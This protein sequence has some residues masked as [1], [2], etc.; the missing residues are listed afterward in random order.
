M[1]L[2]GA[3]SPVSDFAPLVAALMPD[4]RVIVPELP[5][6]GKSPMLAGEYSF[7]RIYAELEMLLL[8]R[9]ISEVAVVGFSL[10]GHHALAL[11]G[12]T[13]IRVT[14]VVSIAGFAMLEPTA[15]DAMHG[16]VAMLSQPGAELD[17]P[18]LRAIARER[19]LAPAFRTAEN[20][21]RVDTW[22][23]ATTAPVLAIEIATELHSDVRPLLPTLQIPVLAL[24]G[25]LDVAVPP[26]YSEQI[27]TLCPHGRLEVIPGHGHALLLEQ[28]AETIAVIR[29]ALA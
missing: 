17:T 13:K 7:A 20:C 5:G 1:L 19:F 21:A 23:A 3:P 9:G 27:A 16:F 29:A 8:D 14:S 22:L 18:E 11:A 28:P 6:Y 12:S 24:V 15:R 25:G 10:G 2:H 26:V 4:Y